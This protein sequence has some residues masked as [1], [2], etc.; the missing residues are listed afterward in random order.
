MLSY[1]EYDNALAVEI[2]IKGFVSKKE[3][4]DT[5]KKPEAFISAR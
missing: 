1:K 2:A 3:F 5:A 4:D